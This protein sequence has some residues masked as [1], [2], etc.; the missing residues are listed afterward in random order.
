MTNNKQRLV[1]WRKNNL[2]DQLVQVYFFRV[3]MPVH[4]FLSLRVCE[5]K[6]QT[7]LRNKVL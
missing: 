4:Y 7:S 5:L 2:I 6:S 3:C 1:I